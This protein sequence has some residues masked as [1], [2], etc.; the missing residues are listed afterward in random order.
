MLEAQS[1]DSIPAASLILALPAQP[2]C[3]SKSQ[4][5]VKTTESSYF[6]PLLVDIKTYIVMEP[7]SVSNML[8]DV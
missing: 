3:I 1:A 5:G 8:N 4:V 2:S 7:E 6:L